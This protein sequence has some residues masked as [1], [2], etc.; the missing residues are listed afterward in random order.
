MLAEYDRRL[1][2]GAFVKRLIEP[3]AAMVGEPA[4]TLPATGWIG[5][6]PPDLAGKPY[7]LHFWAKWRD[8]SKEDFPRLKALKKR[9]VM[10]LGMHPPETP[11]EEVEKAIVDHQLGY[12]TLLAGPTEGFL[13]HARIGG[14]PT[15]VYP[16]CIMVDAR[17]QI[18]G[19]GSLT[20]VLRTFGVKRLIAPRKPD[21]AG[22]SL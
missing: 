21:A 15:G 4:P 8:S 14:Y 6:Q 22:T 5:G 11:P 3:I 2:D 20:D 17:G 16:Y 10:V 7:L 9:G 1:K 12:P 13:I 18:A 19:H